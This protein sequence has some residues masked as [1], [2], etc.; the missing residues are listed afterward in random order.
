MIIKVTKED[1][2][3]GICKNCF[4]CPIAIALR[5][6]FGEIYLRIHD[7]YII[8][9]KEINNFKIFKLPNKASEFIKKFDRLKSV[10]PFEFEL[11]LE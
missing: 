6:V 7:E 10:E 8:L 5:R 4:Y 1:I 9:E 11:N 3:N 2:E